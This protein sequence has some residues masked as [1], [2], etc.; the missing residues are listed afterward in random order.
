MYK[1][2][3]SFWMIALGLIFVV[4]SACSSSTSTGSGG[5]QKYVFRGVTSHHMNDLLSQAFFLFKEKIEKKSNGQIT[6]EYKG[7]PETIPPMEL[8]QAVGDGVVDIGVL[9]VA[10]YASAIPEDLVLNYSELSHEEEVNNGG[11]DFLNQLHNDKLNVQLLGRGSDYDFSIYLKEK[12]DSLDDFKGLRLRGT[13][14]YAPLFEALG[15]ELVSM[16]GGE[17]Y[18]ALDKGVIDG[19]GWTSVGIT[20][21]GLED[22]VKYMV[23]PHYYKVDVVTIMNL[24]KWN[25]LPE[26]LKNMMIEVQREVEKELPAITEK[27]EAEEKPKLDKA[28]IKTIDLGQEFLQIANNAGWDFIE[29]QLPDH[30]DKLKELFRK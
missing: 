27:Y 1:V 13:P 15:A 28:G 29:K 14:T 4:V 18:D 12:V 11:M 26:D 16:S 5:D 30:K 25:A 6:F 24:D 2:K 3:R 8:G 22:Q 23:E 17:I 20:Q 7:G 9:P 21:L 19:F 10:Y